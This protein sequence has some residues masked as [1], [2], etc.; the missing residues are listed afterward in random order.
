MAS[1]VWHSPRARG[2]VNQ[3]LRRDSSCVI[4]LTHRSVISYSNAVTWGAALIARL[5]TAHEL[6][7]EIHICVSPCDAFFDLPF[8]HFG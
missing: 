2:F 7:E 6:L 4:D 3:R 8:I 5:L 1:L